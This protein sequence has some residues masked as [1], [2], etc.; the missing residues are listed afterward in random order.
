M[1]TVTTLLLIAALAG[2]R[3][4]PE[5]GVH[6]LEKPLEEEEVAAARKEAERLWDVQPRSLTTAE[7][8]L[9]WW[10]R[11]A[12]SFPDDYEACWKG[13]RAAAWIAE[14]AEGDEERKKFAL[15]GIELGNSAAKE[16]PDGAEGRYQR[17]IAMGQ[18]AD[19][20]HAYG[21]DAVSKMEE[22]CLAVIAADE[23]FDH[24][25][26]HRFVGIL[27]TECPGPPTSIGSIRKAKKHLDRALELAP[28]WLP[29]HL[30]RGRLAEKDDDPERAKKEFQAVLDAP[31]PRGFEAEAEE[32]R[33][34]AKD[35]LAR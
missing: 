5:E 3:S 14:R 33:R 30:W 9:E 15:E 17:A 10:R 20:D 8:S 25:A 18:L 31:T 32:W 35:R 24:A 29:N 23:G 4:V 7:S 12:R 11:I 21:V 28:G 26:G 13:A 27:Y 6:P 2:C 34:D 1:R 16:K 22:D 19:V